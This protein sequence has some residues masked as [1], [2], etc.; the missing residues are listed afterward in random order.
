[1]YNSYIIL[2]LQYVC[3]KTVSKISLMMIIAALSQYS[4]FNVL[5]YRIQSHPVPSL[6][7]WEKEDK[8]ISIFLQCMSYIYN[9]IK[10]MKYLLNDLI[11]PDLMADEHQGDL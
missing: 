5:Q 1:M 8:F 3:S 4:S 2:Q 10:L 7:V 11:L 6:P 9:V